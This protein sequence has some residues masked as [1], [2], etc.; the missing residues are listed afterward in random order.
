MQNVNSHSQ[1]PVTAS[2]SAADTDLIHHAEDAGDSDSQETVTQEAQAS[3]PTNGHLA[4]GQQYASQASSEQSKSAFGQDDLQSMAQQAAS[5]DLVSELEHEQEGWG[6]LGSP[7][8]S[9]QE[10]VQAA[11]MLPDA[12]R[13]SS[14]SQDGIQDL[15]TATMQL[16]A[17]KD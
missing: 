14:V 1:A 3:E 4:N 17:A 7:V 11:L 5:G 10:A 2:A 16:L 15:Q 8:D 12:L 6:G 9:M 13:I